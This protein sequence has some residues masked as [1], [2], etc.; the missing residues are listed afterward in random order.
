MEAYLAYLSLLANKEA[1]LAKFVSQ[2]KEIFEKFECLQKEA[3][4]LR[5]KSKEVFNGMAASN[6]EVYS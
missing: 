6:K 2:H 3:E 5:K 1:Q 4:D